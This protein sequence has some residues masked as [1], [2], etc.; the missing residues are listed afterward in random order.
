MHPDQNLLSTSKNRKAASYKDAGVALNNWPFT[1]PVQCYNAASEQHIPGRT[2][3]KVKL[4]QCYSP[5]SELETIQMVVPPNSPCPCWS[6]H[7]HLCTEPYSESP[8][9]ILGYNPLGLKTLTPL[10]CKEGRFDSMQIPEC[11]LAII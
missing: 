3:E 11:K 6:Q 8:S 2:V 5:S 9:P 10:D 1:K 4:C 7:Q